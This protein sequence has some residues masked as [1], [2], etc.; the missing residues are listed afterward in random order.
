MQASARRLVTVPLFLGLAVL[1]TGLLPLLILLALPLSLVPATRGALPT[2][3][4]VAGY[5]WCETIGLCGALAIRIRHRNRPT[6]M[7]ANFK[8]QCWWANT[9]K[10]LAQTFFRLRFSITGADVL[11]GSP[12]IMLPRHA[13]IAD[14]IIPIV[15]YAAPQQIHLRYV[16]K[17][18]L[19]IDPCLDIVGN[20]LPNYFV[21]RSG[22]DSDAAR[23]GV[24]TLIANLGPTEGALIYP[25]G[26]RASPV[27]R[28][29]LQ[30]RYA[31]D[32][33]ML[34]QI[35]RWPDLLPPRLGGTLALLAANPGL[36]VVFCAH[37]GFEGSSHFSNL[38][39]GAWLGAHIRLHFWRVPFAAIP[40]D[41]DGRREFLFGQ[42]DEM[43]RHV[44]AMQSQ[45]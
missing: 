18:E 23:A 26:T 32:D 10:A 45:P 33:Q 36:D 41:P 19:L 17:Q 5:L 31:D 34:A 14:T 28:Q 13:S 37:S 16:I 40:K 25:E 2:I 1:V 9:L 30:Q 42:W 22:Q 44:S 12:A 8:L 6:Y 27:K 24:A 35:Q 38:V 21:D 3:G 39:N 20:R 4:F 11:V 7:A 15:Y 43:Q 29:R